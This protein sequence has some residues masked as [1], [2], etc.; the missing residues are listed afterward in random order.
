MDQIDWIIINYLFTLLRLE[1]LILV[2]W[3]Y[4]VNIMSNFF[5]ALALQRYAMYVCV[6]VDEPRL[7]LAIN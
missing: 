2:N 5:Q 6:D 1:V 7:T 3:W 4:C